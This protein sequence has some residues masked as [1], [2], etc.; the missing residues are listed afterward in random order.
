[1]RCFLTM[2]NFSSG[3]DLFLTRKE[4]LRETLVDIVHK[5]LPR[6][7]EDER[8]PYKSEVL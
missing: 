1:M 7:L 6:H 3:K 4:T 8:V 5:R 2:A